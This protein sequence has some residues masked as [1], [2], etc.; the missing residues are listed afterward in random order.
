MLLRGKSPFFIF[1][2]SVIAKMRTPTTASKNSYLDQIET[3]LNIIK[4]TDNTAVTRGAAEQS[5]E[6]NRLKEVVEKSVF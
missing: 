4:H 6:A 1:D 5:N 3:D 2:G